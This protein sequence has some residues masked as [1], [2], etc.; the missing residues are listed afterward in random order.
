MKYQ[1]GWLRVVDRKEGEAWQLRY[2]AIDPDG[3]RREKTSIIGLLTKFPSRSDA[4]LEVDRLGLGYRINGARVP[5]PDKARFRDIAAFYLNHNTFTRLA[6]TTQYTYRHIINDILLAEWGDSYAVDLDPVDI[7]NWLLDQ[8]YAG[9]T[10]GKISYVMAVV[11]AVA[12]KY[13]KIPK[14]TKASVAD[15]VDVPTASDYVATI[16]TPEQ[17]KAMLDW[18]QQPERTMALLTALT[19][20]RVSEMLGLQWQDI[21]W[22][23]KQIHVRRRYIAGDVDLPKTAASRAPVPMGA[24]LSAALKDWQQSTA[25]RAPQDW[26]FAS[27]ATEGKTPRTGGLTAQDYLRPAAVAAGVQVGRRFGW[28]NLRHSLST[29]IRKEADPRTQ[30]DMMRHSN[31]STTVLLYQQSAMADRVAVQ[32]RY[33]ARILNGTGAV[34]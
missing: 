27:R 11:Y 20:L 24:V 8:Q 32:E 30:A 28:H 1:R 14:G 29:N 5:E 10:M 22:L 9:P 19:G 25:Y 31:P 34:Q 4:W 21:D 26:L 13:K 12:E 3:V 18:L 17:L 6:K 23:G 15:L 7:E 16:V 2:N 33:A